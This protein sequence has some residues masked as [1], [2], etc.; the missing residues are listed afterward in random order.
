MPY[1]LLINY[2]N[3]SIINIIINNNIYLNE[4]C[5][6]IY[7]Y[8]YRRNK[9]LPQPRYDISVILFQPYYKVSG[10]GSRY[11]SGRFSSVYE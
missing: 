6:Q 5:D 1:L 8:T 7:I 3:K 11:F 10:Y 4:V 9:S 2:K